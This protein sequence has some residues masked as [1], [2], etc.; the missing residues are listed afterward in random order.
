[1]GPQ[2]Q[3]G[4]GL[5]VSLAGDIHRRNRLRVTEQPLAI[6]WHQAVTGS[7]TLLPQWLDVHY[8]LDAC[9]RMVVVGSLPVVC[10]QQWRCVTL[11]FDIPV[12]G[13]DG[14]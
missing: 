4:A 7:S 5:T 2:E 12:V 6:V 10:R 1:M 14:G 13:G 9:M 11:V 8:F 3:V